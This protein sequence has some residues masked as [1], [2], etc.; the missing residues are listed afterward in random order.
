MWEYGLPNFS[1]E[2]IEMGL[3]RR[4]SYTLPGR[5]PVDAV[6]LLNASSVRERW[7]CIGLP[8]ILERNTAS[9]PYH[10]PNTRLN[11]ASKMRADLR[12]PDKR[13]TRDANQ[14]QTR[15]K[16]AGIPKDLLTSLI[17]QENKI[18]EN[19]QVLRSDHQ[20]N[21]LKA[22]E[23]NDRHVVYY[24]TG[25][26]L[27]KLQCKRRRRGQSHWKTTCEAF[28]LVNSIQQI[29]TFG[30]PAHYSTT[31]PVVITRG[32]SNCNVVTFDADLSIESMDKI[33]FPE[34]LYHVCTSPHV[35]AEAASLGTTGKLFTWTPQGGIQVV[36]HAAPLQRWIRSEY[37][38][39]PCVL[40]TANRH[41]V[42]TYDVRIPAPEGFNTDWIIDF[43]PSTTEIVDIKRHPSCPFQLVVRTDASIDILDV[44]SPSKSMIQ[45]KHAGLYTP[46]EQLPTPTTIGTI[47][48]V[49]VSTPEQDRALI[50]SGSSST[51]K[52]SVHW[53][54]GNTSVETTMQ[55]LS[56]P[57]AAMMNQAAA[58]DAAFDIHLADETPWIHQIGA[59]VVRRSSTACDVLQLSSLG[60]LF[61]QTLELTTDPIQFQDNLR[62]GRTARDT[63]F[64]DPMAPVHPPVAAK[65]FLP[66]YDA[67]SLQPF[68]LLPVD[69][70]QRALAPVSLLPSRA[71][72][73]NLEEHFAPLAPSCTLYALMQTWQTSRPSYE[74]LAEAIDFSLRLNLRFVQ[75]HGRHDSTS[76]RVRHLP[77]ARRTKS[78]CG[79]ALT[80]EALPCEHVD[81]PLPH[82]WIVH[83]TSYAT[84][85]QTTRPLPPVAKGSSHAQIVED[86]EAVYG[87]TVDVPSSP[88]RFN[89][90]M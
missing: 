18:Q 85:V 23:W 26:L 74:R 87:K 57:H 63:T 35:E 22:V 72:E 69:K 81:C 45:W 70:V 68:R 13:A 77:G 34:M 90:Q 80:K 75:S 2:Y 17:K 65:A 73:F 41:A 71:L 44:R 66:S 5:I 52:V 24:P 19:N 42:G 60:D 49:D 31:P 46:A 8:E 58:G 83:E 29:E 51:N 62:S 27:H 16:D 25:E 48:V 59:C 12:D 54:N 1:R 11:W 76:M 28:D 36:G 15:F 53:Y 20:G 14:F 4:V 30:S 82:A 86:L 84:S 89:K 78:I 32:A 6:R 47:D 9:Y 88:R 39:H 21:A 7:E 37:S 10:V 61:I 38:S 56:A 79:C 3:N 40:W 64:N 33:S 55:R 43:L 50:V 67:T